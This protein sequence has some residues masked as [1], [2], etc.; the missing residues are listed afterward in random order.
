M[1]VRVCVRAC[2]CV[3][4][5]VCARACVRAATC[6]CVC[7]RACCDV[8]VC[9][10]ACVRACARARVCV[11]AC[12]C[13]CVHA[14]RAC[15]MC[16][17]AFLYRAGLH[18]VNP[19]LARAN[20]S[21]LCLP[22]APTHDARVR[23][24]T[25]TTQAGDGHDGGRVTRTRET[26]RNLRAAARPPSAATRPARAR[27]SRRPDASLGVVGDVV[28]AR[29][30]AKD[31]A[32]VA[33]GQGAAAA[34]QLRSA[35]EGVGKRRRGVLGTRPRAALSQQQIMQQ[36]RGPAAPSAAARRPASRRPPPDA[37]HPLRAPSRARPC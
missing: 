9:V 5:C 31:E 15:I 1:R 30:R 34:H 22:S 24:S 2:A 32:G 36:R 12:V 14:V 18:L 35:S 17:R 27:H 21:R 23:P 20:R 10:R 6:V 37:P 8:C 7:V 29:G 16:V 3:R 4:V 33:V 13:V 19:S 26:A 28:D 25:S 11:C